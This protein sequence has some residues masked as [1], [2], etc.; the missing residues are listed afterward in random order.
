M[1]DV[2]GEFYFTHHC[3]ELI[4]MF[5]KKKKKKGL[6]PHTY[7]SLSL[8]GKKTSLRDHLH[9]RLKIPTWR[10]MRWPSLKGQEFLRSGIQGVPLLLISKR[11]QD[12]LYFTTWWFQPIFQM[13]SISNWNSCPVPKDQEAIHVLQIT[14][15]Q[16]QLIGPNRGTT[17]WI[18][19]SSYTWL[20]NE[21]ITK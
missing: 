1:K 21:W 16:V 14:F 10:T 9:V 17:G 5:F 12:I 4:F 8:E 6:G 13:Y 15:P 7:N 11:P 3:L 2:K 20:P 18:C 19:S